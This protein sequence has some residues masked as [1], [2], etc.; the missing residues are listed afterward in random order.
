[1]KLNVYNVSDLKLSRHDVESEESSGL[2]NENYI[3]LYF[4]SFEWLKENHEQIEKVNRRI[5]VKSH[6]PSPKLDE[7]IHQNLQENKTP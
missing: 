5:V 6:V 2:K 3:P 4:S 7:N 1:L